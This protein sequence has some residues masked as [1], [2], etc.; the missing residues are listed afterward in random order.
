[1]WIK[2]A[3]QW[4][5][6][7]PLHVFPLAAAAHSVL[8]ATDG[9]GY[10]G[11]KSPWLFGSPMTSEFRHVL[12]CEGSCHGCV[13]KKM[14]EGTLFA[15]LPVLTQFTSTAL[16]LL[17]YHH[18]VQHDGSQSEG[19]VLSACQAAGETQ[20][21]VSWPCAVT[22]AQLVLP[23]VMFVYPSD[24]ALQAS[25]LSMWRSCLLSFMSFYF[26][27]GLLKY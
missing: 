11:W 13:I 25:P 4:Q 26:C 16:L 9:R 22:H 5:C 7:P 1:M 27:W 19:T 3:W 14:D 21:A 8:T 18:Y 6:F 24:G 23:A 17:T 20:M 10:W 15:V 12:S 2:L